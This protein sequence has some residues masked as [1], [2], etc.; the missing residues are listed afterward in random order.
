MQKLT[1]ITVCNKF[2]VILKKKEETNIFM[3]YITH[4]VH[5]V[6]YYH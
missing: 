5:I 2:G 1:K 4:I 6:L 3:K